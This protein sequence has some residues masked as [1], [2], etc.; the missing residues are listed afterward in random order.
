M[1]EI[2]KNQGGF[3]TIGQALRAILRLLVWE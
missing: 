1:M 2:V 3:A